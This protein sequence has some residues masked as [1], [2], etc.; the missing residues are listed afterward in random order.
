[1][2]SIKNTYLKRDF[3]KWS[4]YTLT[5]VIFIA[6]PI[7]TIFIKLFSGP[8]ET[9]QHI[10][11]NL[12]VDYTINSLWL[13]FGCV[14]L[15]LSFGVSSA[16]IVSRYKIPFQSTIEWMLILPLAIPSYITAY[17]Y[18]GIFDYG[19]SLEL[20]LRKVGLSIVK[21]DIMNIYGLIIV[22][23]LSLFPYVYVSFSISI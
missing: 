10:V 11:R 8:G 15:T 1:M 23:S 17:A 12:L 16:W 20:L 19:G 6:V 2:S 21:I 3:N 18:T 22:L 14:I 4:I 13:I 9:W 5:I 7:L